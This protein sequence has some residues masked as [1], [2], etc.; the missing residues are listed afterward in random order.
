M[1]GILLYLLLLVSYVYSAQVRVDPLVLISSQG[2]IRGHAATDGDYS[3]FL[4]IPYAQV[5]ETN[6]FG[7]ALDPPPFHEIIHDAVDSVK[8]PQAY[9]SS[10]G[11]TMLD[12]LRLNIYVPSQAHSRNPLP[13]LVWIHGGD[14]ATGSAGDYGVRNLVRHGVVVVTMNYRLGPYGF[15]CLNIPSMPGNQGLKDQFDALRWIRKNIAS[16]GG[17]PYNVT[18]AGQDAGA[19]SALL[20]LY[21]DWDKLFHKVI[22]ESGTPQSEGMFVNADIDAALKLAEYLGF[23]TSDTEDALQFL[24]KSS[25]DLVTG[26]AVD[27]GL[28]LRPCTERFFSGISNLVQDN[29]YSMSNKGK[30]A[31]TAILIGNTNKEL[32]SLSGDYFNSDPFY[33]K[34]RNNF[35]LE[36]HQFVQ[37]ATNVRHF[38]IGDQPISPEVS[39][40]LE[41]FETDFVYNHPSQRVITR[42]LEDNAGAI[43]EYLFSYISNSDADG[44][45]HSSELNYLFEV[46]G[47]LQR[48]KED[49]LIVDRMTTLWTNFIKFGNPTPR[50]S[51]LVPVAWKPVTASTRPTMIIDTNLRL[52][53]RV[54]QQR[55]A[56]WDLFYTMYGRYNNIARSVCTI[57]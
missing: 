52:D 57:V 42:L 29:P 11:E 33:V 48:T 38:Y 37:A 46:G 15:M 40:E 51:E 3:I 31:N 8:C 24:G 9:S 1:K 20:H 16:F 17:N 19:T 5:D 2:L 28:Q 32:N 50:T 22:I 43:Y 41:D 12:C 55:M 4:G 56:Y 44:A 25:P 45:G 49:Q 14:F 47:N 26:A 13:V 7:P 39:S 35:D 18:I 10:I 36:E 27:L 53:S 30:V 54:D 21:S 6:P 23:N 34:I